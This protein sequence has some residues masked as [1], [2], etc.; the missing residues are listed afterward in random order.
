L[1]GYIGSHTVLELLAPSSSNSSDPA[2]SDPLPSFGVVVIDNLHNSHLESLHRVLILAQKSWDKK[3]IPQSSR[4][5][6]YFHDVN[7]CDSN[8]LT[9]IIELYKSRLV[10]C[11]HFAALKSVPISTRI[12]LDYYSVNVGGTLNLV[13]ALNSIGCK[14]LVFS[15]SV[16]VY[17]KD[18]E[19][20]GVKIKEEDCLFG[21]GGRKTTNPYGR[22]KWMCEE[23]LNDL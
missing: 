8:R 17:G 9:E 2:S 5:P 16:V 11:I 14:F 20:K 22:S 4:P 1:I 19:A 21:D 23:I 6:L 12:P 7:L 18:C 3:K 10:G 15:S 13:K